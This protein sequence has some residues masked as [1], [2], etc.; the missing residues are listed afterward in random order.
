MTTL[1][2]FTSALVCWSLVAGAIYFL[3]LTWSQVAEW[4]RMHRRRLLV[5]VQARVRR[6]GAP[7]AW[8]DVPQLSNRKLEW[9]AANVRR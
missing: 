2:T 9:L 5:S 1:T 4:R 8:R 3:A 6:R 7:G